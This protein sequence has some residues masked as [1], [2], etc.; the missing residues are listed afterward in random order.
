MGSPSRLP[1][2][3]ATTVANDAMSNLDSI[4]GL[5]DKK[6]PGLLHQGY[7]YILLVVFA[8]YMVAFVQGF[9]VGK[10]RTKYKV[11][12]PTMYSDTEQMFNCY[13]RVHQNTLER[14]PLFLAIILLAGLFNS[15]IAAVIGAIWVAGRVIYS[16]GYY[17][18]VPNNRIVGSLMNLLTESAL[19]IMVLLQGGQMADWWNIDQSWAAYQVRRTL[20]PKSTQC[21]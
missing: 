18:G 1:R 10:A 3:M 16:V 15:I 13:Q 17:S 14:I 5:L 9:L 7:G 11:E 4:L 6:V 8:T 2:K 12:L 19:L 21:P 20:G